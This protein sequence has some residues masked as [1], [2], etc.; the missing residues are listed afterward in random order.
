MV[1]VDLGCD[2]IPCFDWVV[3]NVSGNAMDDVAGDLELVFMSE[4]VSWSVVR[5]VPIS[6]GHLQEFSRSGPTGFL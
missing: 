1:G 3:F 4:L 6:T 5:R 2:G